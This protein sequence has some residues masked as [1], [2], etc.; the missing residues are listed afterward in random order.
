MEFIGQHLTSGSDL[1]I[2]MPKFGNIKNDHTSRRTFEEKE[3]LLENIIW[4]TK[5][6]L[7]T[8]QKKAATLELL[9]SHPYP[10]YS[11]PFENSIITGW[12]H[13]R[14]ATSSDYEKSF[15][16][17]AS[18]SHESSQNCG[19]WKY[20]KK[21]SIDSIDPKFEVSTSNL[22]LNGPAITKSG[23][24]VYPCNK[25]HCSI[26]C[27][28]KLCQIQE[29]TALEFQSEGHNSQCNQHKCEMER[30]SQPGDSFTI[31]FYADTLEEENIALPNGHGLSLMDNWIKHAGIPRS[32]EECQVDLLDHQIHHHVLHLQ[33]K[34]CKYFTRLLNNNPLEKIWKVHGIQIIDHA[35]KAPN[36]GNNNSTIYWNDEI[37]CKF[38]YKYFSNPANRKFH[39]KTE[40]IKNNQDNWN[41][42]LECNECNLTFEDHVQASLHQ[43]VH[44]YLCAECHY[45]A[46]TKVKLEEHVGKSHHNI[47]Q[48]YMKCEKCKAT[49]RSLLEMSIHMKT[50]ENRE[51]SCVICSQSRLS[52]VR[53]TKH[54]EI[55]HGILIDKP[56][57]CMHCKTSF[58]SE[59]ALQI[60]AEKHQ[61]DRKN[62][63]CTVC[64]STFAS[65][66]NLKRHI[67]TIHNMDEDEM[68][69]DK[70][71]QKFQRMDNLRRHQLEVH[72]SS[73]SFNLAYCDK[74]QKPW[75]CNF[76]EECFKR[77]GTL[78]DHQRE[79]HNNEPS[80][81]KCETCG[82]TFNRISN[83]RR[84]MQI[85][86][87]L[88]NVENEANYKCEKCGKTF[89]R[90]D[91]L[92]KHVNNI[93]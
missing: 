53:L 81:V 80:T 90:K 74:Y 70:C 32:C 49:F 11:G 21:A 4:S 16:Y 2:K 87:K 22:T 65:E 64:H 10:R 52:K 88:L 19:I 61:N 54:L 35:F 9:K 67:D 66:V 62:Y 59:M 30:S 47:L 31:P 63:S 15:L 24:I 23:K 58:S 17:F 1:K 33:C 92:K 38:C 48:K 3:S 18:F 12:A 43:Q 73:A 44:Q 34:F 56:F 14:A 46:S 29:E 69:C 20:D 75:K 27:P 91:N 37:T 68:S 89:G 39:E 26:E 28:C 78:E 86:K 6:N 79:V 60:H 36:M 51:L 83:W 72:K 8:K 57:L 76:C 42:Y 77:K 45:I 40:H 5:S 84:H 71:G 85:H 50:H 13:R 93:H 25:G 55:V 41:F 82:K 7:T